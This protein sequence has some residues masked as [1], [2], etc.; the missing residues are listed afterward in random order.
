MLYI[1][2]RDDT[3]GYVNDNGQTAVDSLNNYD[4]TIF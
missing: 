3:V 2:I 4:F 1:K